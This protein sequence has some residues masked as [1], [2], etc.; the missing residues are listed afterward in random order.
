MG[1]YKVDSAKLEKLGSYIESLEYGEGELINI[2]REAQE[3][4]GYLPSD[5]QLFVA[6]K[7]G[8]PAAK[9]YGVATFYSYF[10]MEPRG[11]H[12]ISVCLGTACFVKG[13]DKIVE[14]FRKQLN[15][16]E[17]TTSEDGMYTIDS[18]RC[19]GACGLAPVVIVDGKVHGRVK[20]DDV[21]AIIK[22]IGSEAQGQQML[23]KQNAQ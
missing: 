4:F 16:K 2:L 9:V 8:I 1:E 5:V 17:G 15:I 22:E 12:I 14:E 3:I 23:V 13:A 20:P 21:A 18:I 11:Q 19:V 10:T 7:L 6:R